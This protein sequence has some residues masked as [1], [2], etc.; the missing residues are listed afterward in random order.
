MG[1]HSVRALTAHGNTESLEEGS[2]FKILVC[3]AFSRTQPTLALMYYSRAKTD[4]SIS[5]TFTHHRDLL[6]FSQTVDPLILRFRECDH[7]NYKALLYS[8]TLLRVTAI[9]QSR[10]HIQHDQLQQKEYKYVSSETLF[11]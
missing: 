11:K 9:L 1:A 10:L 3:F 5:I 8:K 4:F 2:I 6:Y 7:R